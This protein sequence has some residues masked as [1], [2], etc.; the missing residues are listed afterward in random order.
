MGTESAHRLGYGLKIAWGLGSVGTVSV[1]T[2]TSLLLL[3]FMTTVLGIEPALAG[4]LLFG[5]K[6]FDAVAAPVMGTVS[7]G[8]NSRWGRRAP[9]LFAGA[10][11]GGLGVA[12][13]FNPPLALSGMGLSAWILASL[14]VLALGYTLFN[15]PYLAMP[16]EMTNDRLERTSIMSW[17]IGFVSLGGLLVG[18]MPQLAT[19]LGGGRQGY[20]A[21]GIILGLAIVVTMGTAA[22]AAL[23]TRRVAS[24]QAGERGFK[25]FLIVFKNRPF[26][27]IMSAK[28]MQL[29]GLASMTASILFLLKSVL[30]APDS[31]VAYYVSGSTAGMLLTLPIWARLNKRFS[32][33]TLYVV[34]C[35]GYATMVLTWLLATRGETQMFILLRGFAVGIFTGGL[36]L[37]GQSLLPDAIDEDCRRSGVRREGVYAGA[38]S[39]IEKAASAV[40]PLIIGIILQIFK[41][42]PSL[43]RDV[44]QPADA[45]TGIYFG[46]AVLPALLY[47]LSVVPL[48]FFKLEPV[49]DIPDPA[50]AAAE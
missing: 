7:D 40:G 29:I 26:V 1:L 16:A 36:L 14:V 5:A 38:Y 19:T 11:F 24:T 6:L 10:L 18:L 32:K 42:Q 45:I 30:G 22:M 33:Q 23:R 44:D 8:W 13:V 47:A 48:F 27:L 31:A 34:G 49:A 3:F 37:M 21:V 43:G 17:R 20:G 35:L 50:P 46:A 15:V 41:F 9:F 12:L 25:R 28:V 4:A 39:L 2:V